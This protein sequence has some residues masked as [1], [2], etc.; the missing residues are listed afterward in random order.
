MS[1]V[2]IAAPAATPTKHYFPPRTILL[3]GI[4]FLTM[5][6]TLGILGRIRYVELKR[7]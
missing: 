1:D 7:A 3:I 4:L 2:S 6:S 5:V